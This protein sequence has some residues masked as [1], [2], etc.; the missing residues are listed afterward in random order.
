MLQAAR[1]AASEALERARAAA[2]S[3]AEVAE[4]ARLWSDTQARIHT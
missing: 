2:P 1:L 4:L 3:E